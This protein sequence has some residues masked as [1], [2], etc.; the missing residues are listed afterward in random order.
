MQPPKAKR[1]FLK[2]LLVLAIL[3]ASATSGLGQ[4]LYEVSY[5]V[6][7]TLKLVKPNVKVNSDFV[8]FAEEGNENSF[9][10]GVFGR[11]R[12]NNIYFQPELLLGSSQHRLEFL[13]YNNVNGFHPNADFQFTS[14]ELP[15][16]IGVHFGDFRINTGPEYSF[17]LKGEEFFLDEKRDVTTAYNTISVLWQF[18]IGLDLSNFLID[19]KHEIGLSKTE[20]TLNRLI[21]REMVAK[22][23][24]LVFS[25]GYAFLNK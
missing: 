19:I 13:N 3:I 23:N 12:V 2:S 22:Q 18:G 25:V 4:Q 15:V 16:P 10:F 1:H 14:F 24:Q 17:L 7:P 8:R 21:E 9:Q 6:G 5:K 11:V 20:E